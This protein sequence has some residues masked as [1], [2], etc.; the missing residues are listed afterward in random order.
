[1]ITA[2]ACQPVISSELAGGSILISFCVVSLRDAAQS[3]LDA[4]INMSWIE[5]TLAYAA[6]VR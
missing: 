2:D 1:M 4:S 6:Y 5:S 3:A